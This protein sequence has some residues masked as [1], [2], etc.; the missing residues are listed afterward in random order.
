MNDDEV[1]TLYDIKLMTRTQLGWKFGGPEK[2]FQ[3]MVLNGH[4]FQVQLT[5]IGKNNEFMVEVA[6]SGLTQKEPLLK[7][8]VVLPERK[9]TVF[10]YEDFLRKPFFI[11]LQR[12]ENQTIIDKEPVQLPPIHI[13]N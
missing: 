4:E 7:T 3:M 9:L 13:S 2:L 5:M 8:H 6:D 10:G 12:E 1:K 11:C